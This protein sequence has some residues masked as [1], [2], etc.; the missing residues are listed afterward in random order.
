M[1][2][3]P[4]DV[5]RL[6]QDREDA[7]RAKDFGAA[8]AI[9]ERIRE[10][11]FEI[12]DTPDG[13]AVA[14]ILA[15]SPQVL[16][17]EAVQSRLDERPGFDATVHW[18]IQGWPDDV[19]RGIESFDRHR[20]DA[21]VQHVVVDVREQP[22]E[23]SWPEDIDVV[24]LRSDTGWAAARNAGLLRTAGRIAVVA[25]GS[26][27]ATGP[28]LEPLERALSDDTVG[29]TGPFGIVT[30][31]LHHFHESEGPDVDAVESYLM[32]LRRELVEAGLRFD[33]KFKFYRTAD[34]ELSFHVKSRGLRATV[35]SLPLTR[36]E[37]RMW[38]STAEE[39]R[40]RLS[41]RNYYRFLDKWR[42]RTDLLVSGGR[43][44]HE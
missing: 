41:K 44:D 40:D 28:W 22:D 7:R 17:P 42:G 15:E 11:G 27:E 9:R 18:L 32:A 4:E 1:S 36:H 12:T 3:V 25:D 13:P 5:H 26:V 6:L 39:Q 35:T 20:G 29:I 24:C 43:H 21:S 19:H 2:D 14:V 38:T 37:H 30:D 10:A 23:A 31:D 34:I 8:D 33:E 16:R